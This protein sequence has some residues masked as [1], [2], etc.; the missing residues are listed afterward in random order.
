MAMLTLLVIESFSNRGQRN[1]I[2]IHASVSLV[3]EGVIWYGCWTFRRVD[4]SNFQ[5]APPDAGIDHV[6]GA[7]CSMISASSLVVNRFL[8]LTGATATYISVITQSIGNVKS[9]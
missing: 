2:G 8:L 5:V 6:P 1:D 7:V 4:R 3:V 9:L